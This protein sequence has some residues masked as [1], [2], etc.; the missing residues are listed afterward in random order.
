MVSLI[1]RSVCVDPKDSVIMRLYCTIFR[2]KVHLF[3]QLS[4]YLFH[5]TFLA[6]EPRHEKTGLLPM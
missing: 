4:I 1:T 5:L 6:N 2:E 3:K